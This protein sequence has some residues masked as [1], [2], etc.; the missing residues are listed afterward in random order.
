MQ[1]FGV[2]S[3]FDKISV[4]CLTPGLE[5]F[6]ITVIMIIRFLPLSLILFTF[7]FDKLCDICALHNAINVTNVC[8]LFQLVAMMRI[9]SIFFIS[10][11]S[12]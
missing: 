1:K 11:C 2:N 5:V 8:G 3:H 12:K 7:I 10:S 6:M 4:G 9:V